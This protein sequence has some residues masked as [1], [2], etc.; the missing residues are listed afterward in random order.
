MFRVYMQKFTA[1]IDI[2]FIIVSDNFAL[3]A[4]D[5]RLE[6]NDYYYSRLFNM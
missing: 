1:S 5:R 6:S 2:Y 3:I 4:V